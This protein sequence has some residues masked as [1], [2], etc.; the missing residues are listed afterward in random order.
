MIGVAEPKQKR[1]LPYQEASPTNDKKKRKKSYMN[2][3]SMGMSEL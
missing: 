1:R 2:N 3:A